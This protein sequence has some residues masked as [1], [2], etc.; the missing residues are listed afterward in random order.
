M[1]LPFPE[2]TLFQYIVAP[3]HGNR[4]QS[5]TAGISKSVCNAAASQDFE[6]NRGTAEESAQTFDCF[7]S[8][9]RAYLDKQKK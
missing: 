9:F 2:D 1:E 3:D 5:K 8:E 7:V 4:P 6:N